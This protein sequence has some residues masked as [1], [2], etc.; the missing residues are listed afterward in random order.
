M[1]LKQI[2]KEVD[3]YSMDIDISDYTKESFLKRWEVFEIS[4]SNTSI[5][6]CV[7][8]LYSTTTPDP[9][10][11]LSF[12]VND[13]LVNRSMKLAIKKFLQNYSNKKWAAFLPFSLNVPENKGKC[14]SFLGDYPD[15]CYYYSNIEDELPSSNLYKSINLNIR[16]YKREEVKQKLSE[17]L[18]EKFNTFDSDD[19]NIIVYG[20]E[21]NG[22]VVGFCIVR[23]D[24]RKG[25][26][27]DY[28]CVDSNY[29][30]RGI[31]TGLLTYLKSIYKYIYSTVKEENIAS[32]NL[33]LQCGF[34]I[35][36]KV[37]GFYFEDDVSTN[38]GNGYQLSYKS[39]V[40]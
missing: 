13:L 2:F 10:Y 36:F 37:Y 31:A 33:N 29:K 20:Y 15:F 24:K 38:F 39:P 11:Y 5:I 9:I 19:K 17:E 3:F 12:C 30:K 8:K 22:V 35:D 28:I 1:N 18:L 25:C 14:W 32:L 16:Q 23:T 6:C 40:K 4:H 34:K 21:E 27:I 26:Y 7:A